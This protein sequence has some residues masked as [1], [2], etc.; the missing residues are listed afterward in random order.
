MGFCKGQKSAQG[1]QFS[2]I[3][4]LSC[5]GRRDLDFADRASCF[6]YTVDLDLKP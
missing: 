2:S 1:C 3:S 6:K 4:N 5:K